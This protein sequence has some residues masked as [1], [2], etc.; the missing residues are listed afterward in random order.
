[1]NGVTYAVDHL[2]GKSDDSRLTSAWFGPRAALK[3]RALDVA[4][5]YATV[6]R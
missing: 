5:E 3:Q 4:V 1:L 2:F 6:R